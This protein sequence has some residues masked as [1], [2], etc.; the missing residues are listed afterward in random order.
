MNN[1]NDIGIYQLKLNIRSLI[2]KK[3][4]LVLTSDML[5]YGGQG[6]LEKYPFF[7]AIHKYPRKKLQDMSYDKIIEFFF[8]IEVFRKTLRKRKVVNTKGNRDRTEKKTTGG[9]KKYNTPADILT[10]KQSNFILMLQLLFP[11]V[12]PVTN[13]ID[14]SIGIITQKPEEE[15]DDGDEDEGEGKKE[16][17]GEEKFGEEGEENKDNKKKKSDSELDLE[18]GPGSFFD[19]N[20]IQSFFSLKG[21]SI[22]NF[23]PLPGRLNRKFSYLKIDG[24]EY[25]ITRTIWLND[26]MNHPVY[27]D[28]IKAY[29]LFE[30]WK[31]NKR[32]IQDVKEKWNIVLFALD[33]S[34]KNT[35]GKGLF[36]GMHDDDPNYYSENSASSSS[37]NIVIGRRDDQFDNMKYFDDTI[38][39]IR[40]DGLLIFDPEGLKSATKQDKDTLYKARRKQLFD[41]FKE[42]QS[43]YDY[44]EKLT[45]LLNRIKNS[46]ISGNFTSFLNNIST[47]ISNL[48]KE[49]SY[50]D[51]VNNLNFEYLSNPELSGVADKI[52]TK[53]PEFNNFVNKI[54][55]MKIRVIDN[56]VWKQVIKSIIRGSKYHNFESKIWNKIDG[57]YGL[58]VEEEDDVSDDGESDDEDGEEEDEEE[59][60]TPE[61]KKRKQ[62][63]KKKE[64]EKL[65]KIGN[66]SSTEK[67]LYVN[68]D[69]LKEK[70]PNGLP[71]MKIIDIFLQI[72]VIE[73]KI[74][75][76][77]MNAINCDYTNHD[78]GS[79]WERLLTGAYS[80]DLTQQ[81]GFYSAKKQL[82]L[83][84]QKKNPP[85]KKE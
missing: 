60:G 19:F 29:H 56:V 76:T 75:D 27:S 14:T 58:N 33:T 2:P 62:E 77:N 71:D 53:Y 46:R 42:D 44:L 64:E 9:K 73:G 55:N 16:V 66:C 10:L 49:K 50:E 34:F 43:L 81:M 17:E 25:T 80:W 52:R 79:T 11:T 24:Q 5:N 21:T 30:I 35:K 4:K 47:K 8:V 63:E 59:E 18:S 36:E 7:S 74:D 20:N 38:A 3:D 78:L 51:Y 26:V 39:K 82:E 1:T 61:E 6:T 32:E 84:N 69:Q 72:D 40:K 15:G 54:Q 12:Y 57:C 70:D 22:F 23:L 45:T 67:V 13:N 28:V 85:E 31:E 65:K 48:N 37:K 83:L 68:F 41:K